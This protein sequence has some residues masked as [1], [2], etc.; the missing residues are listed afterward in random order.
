M[1][2]RANKPRMN[3]MHFLVHVSEFIF[4]GSV[5][6]VLANNRAQQFHSRFVLLF[7][8]FGVCPLGRRREARGSTEV[9]RRHDTPGQSSQVSAVRRLRLIRSVLALGAVVWWLGRRASDLMVWDRNL[10]RC[11]PK[12]ESVR[13]RFSKSRNLPNVVSILMF[14]NGSSRHPA[15]GVTLG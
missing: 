9:P 4:Q 5:E 15:G 14:I 1:D 11:F 6:R 12:Q 3:L 7:N 8:I 10:A 2:T 13:L